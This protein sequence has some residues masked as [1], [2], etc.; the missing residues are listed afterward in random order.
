ML[1]VAGGKG[2][3]VVETEDTNEKRVIINSQEC[4]VSSSDKGSE[5]L[6]YFLRD[7][8]DSLSDEGLERIVE[9]DP[10]VVLELLDECLV[11]HDNTGSNVVAIDKEMSKSPVDYILCSELQEKRL[12]S[13]SK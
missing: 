3:T 5:G 4:L 12:D 1:Q 2:A 6:E 10:T 9:V 13:V 11:H 7:K 8:L